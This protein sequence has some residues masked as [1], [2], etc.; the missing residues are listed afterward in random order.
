[1]EAI[2]F[3]LKGRNAFFR[4]PEVNSIY[5]PTYGHIHK[6]ALLGI[7]G[8]ILGYGG[9]GHTRAQDTEYPEFYAKLKDTQVGIVPRNCK[10]AYFFKKIQSFNN[11]VGYAS[12]EQGG[13][14]IVRE[15]WLENPCW[16]I[17]VLLDNEESIKLYEQLKNHR[18]VYMP[19]L[20]SNDHMADILN[21]EKVT[22][23]EVE[24][25]NA[26]IIGLIPG[27]ETKVEDLDD[28]D[29]PYKY[30]EYLPIALS[31]NLNQHCLERFICSNMY[32]RV[33]GYPVYQ[34]EQT[35]EKIVLF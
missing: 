28:I 12:Q 21:V 18:C 4:N 24:S 11:S 17:Y 34:I 7:F 26:V 22:L 19:Y 3:T 1:M 8:A 31:D 16:D 14:L 15:Q 32:A 13:N 6:V 20:G 29:N 10:N 27:L 35:K 33:Q 9:Y 2:K 23:S 30:E 25:D 5:Y